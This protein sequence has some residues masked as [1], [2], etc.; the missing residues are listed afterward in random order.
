MTKMT[1]TELVRN[2]CKLTQQWAVV[3]FPNGSF[4]FEEL[5]RAIP[6]LE[7]HCDLQAIADEL[8]IVLCSSK[9]KCDRVFNQIRGD[10]KPELNDY[11]GPC[12]IYAWTCG[13]D[14]EI[15]TENT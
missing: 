8:M 15:L 5:Q 2:H 9:D 13:P 12:H 4:G 6:F 7:I 3:L 1:L 11:D 14:G 10:D